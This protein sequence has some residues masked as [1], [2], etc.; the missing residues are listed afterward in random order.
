MTTT[1]T[2]FVRACVP[3]RSAWSDRTTRLP[4]PGA[5]PGRSPWFAQR[6]PTSGG[7]PEKASAGPFFSRGMS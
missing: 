1:T 5:M 7:E 4:D 3:A 2:A 6:T